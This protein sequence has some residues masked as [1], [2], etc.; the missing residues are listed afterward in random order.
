MNTAQW[1]RLVAAGGDGR[2]VGGHSFALFWPF[3]LVLPLSFFL[4]PCVC[5]STGGRNA[6]TTLWK[7]WK[8]RFVLSALPAPAI[9]SSHGLF[10]YSARFGQLVCANMECGFRCV[11]TRR[12]KSPELPSAHEYL[13]K[14]EWT[15]DGPPANGSQKRNKSRKSGRCCSETLCLAAV[16]DEA[17]W[18][19]S[20]QPPRLL[21]L[22]LEEKTKACAPINSKN[23]PPSCRRFADPLCESLFP[24]PCFYY[25]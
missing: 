25:K 2:Q 6:V 5:C 4:C 8:E 11:L 7:S 19:R 20:L 14:L 24:S 21:P 12:V 15:S 9:D 3:S 16:M 1:H 18:V 17:A 22:F 10:L 23:I 13:N